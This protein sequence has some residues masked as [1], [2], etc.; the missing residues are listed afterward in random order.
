MGK[1]TR[2]SFR[3]AG[4]LV[5]PSAVGLR[6][7]SVR[8]ARGAVMPWHSTDG[9][10]ELLLVLAG[11]VRLEFQTGQGRVRRLIVRAGQCAFLSAQ[12]LHQ[13]VNPSGAPANYLY[14]TAPRLRYT[15]G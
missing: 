13:V 11:H 4:R 6:A 10:E 1:V 3:R 2:R 9:R 8:L 12:T 5:P 15:C 7:R 14:V